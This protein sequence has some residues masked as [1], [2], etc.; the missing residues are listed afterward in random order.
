[1]EVSTRI[2]KRTAPSSSAI[3]IGN[4]PAAKAG[5]G[6]PIKFCTSTRATAKWCL[7]SGTNCDSTETQVQVVAVVK[8]EMDRGRISVSFLGSG[9]P[10]DS[11]S[12][13]VVWRDSKGL[14]HLSI[15]HSRTAF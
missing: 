5:V 9:P 13:D 4:S 12:L 1:M 2:M 8:F 14:W 10:W 11:T 15:V 7:R 3:S 6:I